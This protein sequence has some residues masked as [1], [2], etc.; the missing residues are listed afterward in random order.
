MLQ[1]WSLTRCL[2]QRKK[3]GSSGQGIFW[4][5]S[6]DRNT[7]FFHEKA[8]KRHQRNTITRP[9]DSNG[10]WQDE[11]DVMGQIFVDYFQELFTSSYPTVSDELLETIHPK[12]TNRMNEVLLQEFQVAKVKKALKQM[13]PLKAPSPDGMP[14]L[15]FQHY[16]PI[17]NFVVIQ[18]EVDFLNHGVAP[19]KFHETHIVLIPKTKNPT[20]VTNYRPISLCNVAYKI[21]SKVV[22]NRMKAVLKD[23]ILKTKVLLFQKGS[24]Q[25]MFLWA[26]N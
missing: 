5:K 25:T 17:V 6:G 10:N 15:F 21:A 23:I 19:P 16:W 7:S 20:R 8:S 26:M 9:L 4:L 18:T 3:C 11:E 1:R 14:P 12:L 22:A 13:H 2:W 24:S